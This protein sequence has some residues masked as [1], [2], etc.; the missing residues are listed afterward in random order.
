VF[1]REREGCFAVLDGAAAA[2][3]HE[4]R[5]AGFQRASDH[6]VEVFGEAR[7]GQVTVGVDEAGRTH[8]FGVSTRGN[9][10]AG[11]FTVW[12]TQ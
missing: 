9:S 5:D 12:P 10:G 6:C 2:N 7:V 3:G 11:A 4:V 8:A 1:F